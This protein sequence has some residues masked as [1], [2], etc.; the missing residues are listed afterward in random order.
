MNSLCLVEVDSGVRKLPLDFVCQVGYG[1]RVHVILV[2]LVFHCSKDNVALKVNNEA[3]EFRD[4]WMHIA[5]FLRFKRAVSFLADLKVKCFW[6]G[7]VQHKL[8][9][10]DNFHLSKKYRLVENRICI[11]Y[12]QEQHH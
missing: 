10:I 3:K 5:G 8:E 11:E 9:S 7:S 12:K 1:P 6:Q 2:I 4:V